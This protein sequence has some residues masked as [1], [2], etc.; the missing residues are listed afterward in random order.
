MEKQ[1]T[2]PPLGGR[3]TQVCELHGTVFNSR[4]GRI[5]RERRREREREILQK[6][7]QGEASTKSAELLWS[8]SHSHACFFGPGMRVCQCSEIHSILAF[9][10][11]AASA[12]E[13]NLLLSL[14]LFALWML[15]RRT[16][17]IC[18]VDQLCDNICFFKARLLS[19]W[20]VWGRLQLEWC[21]SA[22][23]VSPGSSW[24]VPH[25][26]F[27]LLVALDQI[28]RRGRVAHRHASEDL[29]STLFWTSEL[30]CA[31]VF[32][33]LGLSKCRQTN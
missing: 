28:R 15:Q 20:S 29:T 6:V 24:S 25:W 8:S 9:F 30:S 4:E 31:H 12:T 1:T 13:L 22:G 19:I 21:L 5:G 11:T 16:E 18:K 7:L 10:L 26:W 3:S 32:P 33:D 14:G 17:R 27:S 2:F 23:A